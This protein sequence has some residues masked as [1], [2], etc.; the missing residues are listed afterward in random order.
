MRICLIILALLFCPIC[1]F[2][3]NLVVNGDFEMVQYS[4][5]VN[6]CGPGQ[7][8][9][10]WTVDADSV[11]IISSYWQPAEGLQSLDL[12][13]VHP[14]G[15]WQYLSTSTSEKYVL[16]FAAAAN[17]ES[18]ELKTMQIS[19]GGTVL[20]TLTL[21]PAGHSKTDMGWAYHSYIVSGFGYDVLR[22]TS[23][24]PSNAF[25]PAIDD[26]SVTLVPEPAS[27]AALLLGISGI[28]GAALKRR[29]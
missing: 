26:V 24:G 9:G 23:L 28:A 1:L 8:I 11:E 2:A 19:W 6:G 7:D 20:D 5:P 10:G 4:M 16:R 17:P 25:G 12:N 18:P 13:G 21:D 3:Q 27:L 29:S 14:G 15:I 22:F